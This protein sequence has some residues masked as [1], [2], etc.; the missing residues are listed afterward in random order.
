MN[1]EIAFPN[2]AFEA[3]FTEDRTGRQGGT[4]PTVLRNP[5]KSQSRNV[6]WRF[7]SAPNLPDHIVRLSDFCLHEGRLIFS[8]CHPW[9]TLRM[10][11]L[12]LRP[13]RHSVI[14]QGAI[15]LRQVN[16][17]VQLPSDYS[18]IIRH[19]H[20]CDDVTKLCVWSDF[21]QIPV[22]PR[23]KI[24]FTSPDFLRILRILIGQLISSY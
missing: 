8:Q 16:V 4:P 18:L 9:Y 7:V 12:F 21:R 22:P 14:W 15:P 11:N 5:M 10:S 6:T 2:I 13:F 1:E 17:N 23:H 24:P 19:T 20:D 3:S